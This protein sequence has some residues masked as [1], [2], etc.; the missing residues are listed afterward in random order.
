MFQIVANVWSS[1]IYY[2]FNFS[3]KK[4]C[5]CTLPPTTNKCVV[6]DCTY[7]QHVLTLI[8]NISSYNMARAAFKSFRILLLF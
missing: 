4:C 1:V 6:L 5:E 8:V 2:K 7:N 3:P